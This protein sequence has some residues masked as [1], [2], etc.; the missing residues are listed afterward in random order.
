MPIPILA[1]NKPAAY[2]FILPK[3]IAHNSIVFTLFA[4]LYWLCLVF[5]NVLINPLQLFNIHL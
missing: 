1:L 3:K 4:A 2:L 5:N